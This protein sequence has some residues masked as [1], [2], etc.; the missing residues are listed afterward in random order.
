MH[1][2]GEAVLVIVRIVKVSGNIIWILIV[3]GGQ[4]NNGGVVLL[5]VVG[6]AIE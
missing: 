6:V 1:P 4:V 5:V 3:G 2:S